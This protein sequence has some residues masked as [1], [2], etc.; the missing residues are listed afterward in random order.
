MKLIHPFLWT[1]ALV[2]LSLLQ[3]W[4]ASD[5]IAPTSEALT[6]ARTTI[7]GETHVIGVTNA[8]SNQVSGVNLSA[9]LNRPGQDPV[10]LFNELGYSALADAIENASPENRVT[11]A[12]QDLG[13]PVNLADSHIA[14]GTNFRAHAEESTYEGGPFLFAKE[15]T[16]TNPFSSV[17]VGEALLDHEIE[18]GFVTLIDKQ[19]GEPA[20]TMGLILTNDFTDR[21]VLLRSV[22]PNDIGS[23]HGFTSGKSAPGYL[24]VGTFFVIPQNLQS[25]VSN[26][27][28]DLKVNGST[29]QHAEMSLAIWDIEKILEETKARKSLVWTFQG[30]AVSLPTRDGYI[31]ARTIVISGT[32]AGTIFSGPSAGDIVSGTIDWLFGGWSE[33]VT[34]HVLENYIA[35]AHDEKLYLQPGDVVHI[36]ANRLGI[37]ETPV[38]E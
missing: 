25:F 38:T 29:R 28:L 4:A 6:F 11:V 22:D 7:G 10:T 13:I 5:T 37:I 18:L 32:P 34:A 24:P 27:T 12:E 20:N 33:P 1:L 14:A 15:V 17:S 8:A 23:G 16:P 19:L 31:P 30:R 35:R 21:D 3:A 36:K 9:Q 2:N 26:I